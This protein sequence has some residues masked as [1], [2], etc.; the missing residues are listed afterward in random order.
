MKL[1]LTMI[2]TTL[3]LKQ[4]ISYN[5]TQN[6]YLIVIIKIVERFL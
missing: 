4:E 2:P 3:F 1:G 5:E 6:L